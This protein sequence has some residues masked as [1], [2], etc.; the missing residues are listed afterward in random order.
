MIVPTPKPTPTTVPVP[1][2]LTPAPTQAPD[3]PVCTGGARRDPTNPCGQVCDNTYYPPAPA[4]T[5]SVC[6]PG[7]LEWIK[8]L[9]EVWIYETST[10][11]KLWSL[12][13]FRIQM[14]SVGLIS[15]DET[16]TPVPTGSKEALRI[17]KGGLPVDR[18]NGYIEISGSVLSRR[19]NERRTWCHEGYWK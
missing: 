14:F 10:G 15:E 4:P 12:S 16:L 8:S 6:T 7:H 9:D 19:T 2:E 11:Q 17:D 1:T 18:T 13:E 5:T 3:C